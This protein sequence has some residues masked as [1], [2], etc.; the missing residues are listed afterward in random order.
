MV[1]RSMRRLR[2]RQGPVPCGYCFQE[3]AT[4]YDHIRPFVYDEFKA[5]AEANLYP[6]C[7]RCNSILGAKIFD[8][9][10]DKREYVRRR[11]IQT[12]H[13]RDDVGQQSVV[14][15]SEQSSAFS[16]RALSQ[17]TR[18]SQ[19]KRRPAPESESLEPLW[20]RRWTPDFLIQRFED[21]Y[22]RPLTPMER[23]VILAD[24]GWPDWKDPMEAS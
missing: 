4:G 19:G 5:E 1:R 16:A 15:E 22:G 3:W 10:K 23:A 13:W 14:Y 9:L 18:T 20:S 2:T 7:R 11:L 24:A 8:S 12:G 17:P 21:T 6:C